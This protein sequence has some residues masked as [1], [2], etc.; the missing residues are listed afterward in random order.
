MPNIFDLLTDPRRPR[1]PWDERL[2]DGR[3]VQDAYS[4]VLSGSSGQ[5][6]VRPRGTPTTDT[7]WVADVNNPVAPPFGGG[8]AGGTGRPPMWGVGGGQSPLERVIAAQPP[9][10]PRAPQPDL[11]SDLPVKGTEL[12][13]PGSGG[14]NVPYFPKSSKASTPTAGM[15][16][17]G[18][19]LAEL[20][21]RREAKPG[22]R[23]RVEDGSVETE[24]AGKPSRLKQALMGV[25]QGAII[26]GARAGWR[27]AVGGAAA[28]AGAGAINPRLM[29]ALTRQ[30]NI[31]YTQGQLANQMG[32]EREQAQTADIAAQTEQR[33][34]LARQVDYVNPDTGETLYVSPQVKARLEQKD[35]EDDQRAQRNT[36]WTD[37]SGN[38]YTGLTA[39]EAAS[40]GLRQRQQQAAAEREKQVA[41]DRK[42]ASSRKQLHIDSTTGDYII[43]DPS[44]GATTTAKKGGKQ[45]AKYAEAQAL[46]TTAGK[47]YDDP[48]NGYN[49]KMTA[50]TE[51]RQQ[52]AGL[53]D[54]PVNAVRN[55]DQIK[56]LN[57]EADKLEKEAE[58]IATK[59]R[60]L[61]VEGDKLAAEA[62]SLQ[63]QPASPQAGG[64]GRRRGGRGAGRRSTSAGGMSMSRATFR[65]NNPRAA[66]MS[67]AD[68]DAIITQ[69]G[70]TPIP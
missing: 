26:G 48:D 15:S 8:Q 41:A 17:T 56:S 60:S 34:A 29:Q 5:P 11:A 53:S 46:W 38:T 21:A 62:G 54:T 58:G 24:Y 57:R 16:P 63:E 40:L 7:S 49:A 52:A 43:F 1:Q 10:D 9:A 22:E 45:A 31:D 19:L 42:A 30:Q 18:R 32:V 64:G 39:Y 55:A 4:E 44:T 25:L 6:A 35:R 28:G 51:K 20:N 37:D 2:P 66:Q 13:G 12:P 27:G 14:P 69:G 47:Q 68:V 65:Q 59:V 23:V 3:S 33:K 36:E 61:Q 67:D 70:Y 50:A